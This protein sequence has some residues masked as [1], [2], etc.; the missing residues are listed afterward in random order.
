[1]PP[2]PT[3]PELLLAV[4][5]LE[6]AE[7]LLLEA[8]EEELLEVVEEELLAVELLLVVVE[9]LLL[10]VELVLPELLVLLPEPFPE[11]LPLA[12]PPLP[13]DPLVV[14]PALVTP[15]PPQPSSPVPSAQPETIDAATEAPVARARAEG[16]SERRTVARIITGISF[17]CCS[18]GEDLTLAAR[19]YR[20]SSGRFGPAR[21]GGARR[22]EILPV[23]RL[24]R[25]GGAPIPSCSP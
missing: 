7:E 25:N 4:E 23:G 10:A 19:A 8:V 6:L 21:A 22:P 12:L 18:A 1:L 20:A 3:I 14:V 13:R 17:D 24:L 9:E 11:L 15:P 2:P 16:R 5:L